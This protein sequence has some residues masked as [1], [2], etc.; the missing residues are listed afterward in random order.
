MT[1]FTVYAWMWGGAG[2][3]PEAG[4][5]IELGTY[6]AFALLLVLMVGVARAWDRSGVDRC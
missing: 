5:M 3:R 6:V 1:H 4:A 2:R